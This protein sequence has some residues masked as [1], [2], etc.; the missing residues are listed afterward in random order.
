MECTELTIIEPKLKCNL[1][2]FNYIKS[3]LFQDLFE[4]SSESL[5]RALF[6]KVY[7]R[8]LTIV[9]PSSWPSSVCGVT[10][11]MYDD[12]SDLRLDVGHIEVTQVI[13]FHGYYPYTQQSWGCSSRARLSPSPTRG[14]PSTT[15]QLL[16]I[17]GPNI[18]TEFLTRLV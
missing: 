15:S 11:P 7:L 18:V 4:Q 13:T 1:I 9:I 17:C 10:P 16:S 14:W 6:G 12:L 5:H 2:R 3:F 8:D